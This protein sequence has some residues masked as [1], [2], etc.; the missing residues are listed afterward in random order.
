M[1]AAPTPHPLAVRARRRADTR[2]FITACTQCPLRGNV[3]PHPV[4]FDGPLRPAF[5]VLGDAPDQTDQRRQRPFSG[6][7]GRTLRRML[8]EA[9]LPPDEGLFLNTVCCNPWGALHREH[10]DACRPNLEAQLELAD[11]DTPLLTVGQT[12][13]STMVPD[14]HLKHLHGSALVIDGRAV[15]AVH[16]PAYLLR[17]PTAR[18]GMKETLRRFRSLLGGLDPQWFTPAMCSICPERAEE[19]D[20]RQMPYC[21]RHKGEIK[22]EANRAARRRKAENR[23]AQTRMEL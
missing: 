6:P 4:P 10:M 13:L 2:A 3:R 1:T 22:K 16:H 7:H 14:G 11:Q 18:P 23:A 9:Q 5:I 19:W 17:D 15:M 20:H 8:T 12:A 21:R